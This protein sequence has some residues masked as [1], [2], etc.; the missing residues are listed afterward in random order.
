MLTLDGDL[1]IGGGP[2]GLRV[3]LDASLPLS[4]M[5]E[6]RIKR[7]KKKKQAVQQKVSREPSL[8]CQREKMLEKGEEQEPAEAS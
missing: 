1:G 7:K 5:R 8:R 3:W 2:P 6:N 4:K